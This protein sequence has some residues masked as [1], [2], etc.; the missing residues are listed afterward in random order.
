MGILL[1]MVFWGYSA[2]EDDRMLEY[3]PGSDGTPNID[4]VILLA[5]LIGLDHF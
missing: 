1:S 5:L 3:G 2:T 4:D